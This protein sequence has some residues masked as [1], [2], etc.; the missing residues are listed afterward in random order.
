MNAICLN[1][2]PVGKP[3]RIVGIEGG[4]GAR[5]RLATLGLREGMDV[6]VAHSTDSG[7]VVIEIHGGRLVLGAG[8]ADKI[9]VA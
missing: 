7:P 5:R 9:V 8:M 3:L 6:R 2:A 1:R 4:H